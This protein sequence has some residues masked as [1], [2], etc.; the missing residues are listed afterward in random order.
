MN[1]KRVTSAALATALLFAPFAGQAINAEADSFYTNQT[2]AERADITNW[3]ANTSQQISSNIASQH[4]DTNNLNGDKYVIQWGDT[5]S[6][7]SE[8][9]GIS[10]A[11]LAYDNN[12]ANIDLIYAGDTLILDRD[13]VVPTDW[14]YSGD[15]DHVANTKVTIN[16]YNDNSD[17]SVN[18]TNSPITE[19]S[20]NGNDN[21]NNNGN[22]SDNKTEYVSPAQSSESSSSSNTTSSD[23]T[24]SSTSGTTSSSSTLDED[25]FSDAIKDQLADKLSISDE[26]ADKLEIDF[27]SASDDEGTTSED[28]SD[29]DV[30]TTDLYSSIKTVKINSSKLT[31]SNAKKLANKI[32]Q[33]MEKGNKLAKFSSKFDDADDVTFTITKDGKSFDFN[34]TFST[35]ADDEDSSSDS[36]SKDSNSSSSSSSSADDEDTETDVDA[37]SISE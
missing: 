30:T 20:N 12:I 1:K 16:N 2:N 5:L 14:H 27:S 23:D 9:T 19:N 36:S 21:D 17:H 29:S 3:V 32:Y 11:K 28:D 33:K 8:A 25:E 22:G 18:I 34:V 35:E 26:E 6:G 7:I 24:D 37:D 15:G 10:V 4:I 13:G 31:T